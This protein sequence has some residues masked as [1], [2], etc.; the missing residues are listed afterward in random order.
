VLWNAKRIVAALA[1]VMVSGAGAVTGELESA[2]HEARQEIVTQL[3]WASLSEARNAPLSPPHEPSNLTEI[4]NRQEILGEH[5][6]PL[7]VD[8]SD[9][10]SE[11]FDI[12]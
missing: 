6:L 10:M 3:G 9:F 7:L 12:T 8:V 2:A 1:G 5:H 4:S 11:S